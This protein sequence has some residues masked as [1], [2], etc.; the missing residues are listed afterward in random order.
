PAN[1]TIYI[2]GHSL[3]GALATMVGLYLATRTCERPASY[4]VYTFAAPTAGLQTFADSYNRFLTNNPPN[5]SWRFYNVWDA[6]PYAWQNLAYVQEKFYPSP[7]PA[8]SDEVKALLKQ[9]A[10]S[11]RNNQYVQPNGN[12]DVVLLNNDVTYGQPG[13]FYDPRYVAETLAD[14][15]NQV[16]Y[17]HN[18]YLELL[19]VK[20]LP[21]IPPT[22]K[23]IVPNNGSSA[24]GQSVVITGANFAQ[25]SEFTSVDFGTV[26]AEYTYNSPT[27]ITAIA[28]AVIGTVDV[29]VTTRYGTS[30]ATTSDQFT[31]PMPAALAP[32]VAAV[33]PNSGP[34]SG[35]TQIAITGGSFTPGCTVTVGGAPATSVALLSLT[36]ISAVTPAGRLGM[37]DVVVKNSTGQA[38]TQ[39]VQFEYKLL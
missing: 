39:K 18:C 21:G 1:P 36:E 37:A 5:Q 11:P 8:A 27:Q 6:I 20:P 30:A 34:R 14:F 25:D 12:V 10:K 16:G 19:R 35:G 38:S 2:T 24:G 17:Q 7:G 32:Y 33:D 22:V 31:A 28:P 23:S 26:P 29:S 13:S 4:S 9:L 3:G 15:L